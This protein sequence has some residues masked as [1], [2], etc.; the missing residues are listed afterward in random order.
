MHTQPLLDTHARN[1]ADFFG[2]I[3]EKCAAS[4]SCLAATAAGYYP[5]ANAVIGD[6]SEVLPTTERSE[7]SRIF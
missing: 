4:S 3:A 6:L 2:E 7:A 5:G 1:H